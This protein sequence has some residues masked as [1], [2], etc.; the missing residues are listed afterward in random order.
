MNDPINPYAA[1]QV[2]VIYAP[3]A[4]WIRSASPSLRKTVLGLNLIY[5]GIMISVLTVIASI[6]ISLATGIKLTPGWTLM[7]L[8]G[9]EGIGGFLL[10]IC[11]I[12]LFLAR[13]LSFIG[14]IV[15]LT[16][17]AETGAKTWIMLSV[18]FE[19]GSVASSVAYWVAPGSIPHSLS[20]IL[21]LC[22]YVSLVF[23]ILFMKKLSS[24]IDRY[25]LVHRAVRVLAGLV[26]VLVFGAASF[27]ACDINPVFILLFLAVMIG[28]LIVFLMYV[29]LLDAL[30]KA[31]KGNG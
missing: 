21:S 12:L 9:G 30:I 19:L 1:P 8:K 13:I 27:L 15:C 31:L 22:G 7:N 20:M 4:E 11:C 28:T 5:W 2:D 24:F 14:P 25:D 3:G 10:I 29:S 16:V 23:F 17:P 6:P 18:L 26:L